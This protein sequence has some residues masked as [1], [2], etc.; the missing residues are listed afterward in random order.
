MANTK[1]RISQRVRA[2]IAKS[3]S[4]FLLQGEDGGQY[5]KALH[6]VLLERGF[7]VTRFN[8]SIDEMDDS[9]IDDFDALIQDRI[10]AL[11]FVAT[12][13]A[14][15]SQRILFLLDLVRKGN[16]KARFFSIIF[17]PNAIKLEPSIFWLQQRYWLQEDP[18]RLELGPSEMVTTGLLRE[19]D[20][21]RSARPSVPSRDSVPPP[22]EKQRLLNEG[23][24]ILVG[25]GEVGKTSL[26]NRLVHNTFRG[27][28]TKTQG[29]HITTWAVRC[30]SAQVRL[31]IWDFGGQEIMHATHQFFL[32]E[33]SL[34]LLVLNG[35]EGGVDDDAEYW[36]KHIETFG[37]ILLSL[38]S[39]TK[40][41]NTLLT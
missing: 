20:S 10:D 36:L 17:D 6:D 4:L 18:S 11:I 7:T 30:R 5:C 35:R 16:G 15:R 39:K 12:S 13:R 27:D 29:I 23:K 19:L 24:L 25:R 37:G 8:R 21:L 33:R 40:L 28:E 41:D 9:I 31:N 32:T 3:P 34:Y 38:W 26:V 1:R 22:I 2:T 14:F